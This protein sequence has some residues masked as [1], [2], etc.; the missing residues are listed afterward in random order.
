MLPR[1]L[2]VLPRSLWSALLRS[3]LLWIDGEILSG[4]E[5]SLL[6]KFCGFVWMVRGAARPVGWCVALGVGSVLISNRARRFYA[7]QRSENCD[8]LYY[9][10]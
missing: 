9:L 6:K 5:Y 8:F 3:V 2:A 10:C 7:V 4:W 1:G